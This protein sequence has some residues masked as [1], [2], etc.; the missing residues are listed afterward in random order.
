MKKKN[1]NKQKGKKKIEEHSVN[2]DPNLLTKK[3]IY[4]LLICL[5]ENEL[6]L[7][8]HQSFINRKKRIFFNIKPK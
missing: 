3:Y 2:V 5:S 6:I 8:L 7:S 1:T 4:F